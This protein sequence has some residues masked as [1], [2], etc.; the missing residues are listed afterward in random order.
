MQ[1]IRDGN[2]FDI[3]SDRVRIV[4]VGI[5][6]IVGQG[7]TN[8]TLGTKFMKFDVP[9]P[10]VGEFGRQN[11]YLQLGLTA[12][13]TA[14]L[15]SYA[16]AATTAL[17]YE[18]I[19][20]EYL[21]KPVGFGTVVGITSGYWVQSGSSNYNY[22][23]IP[24]VGTASTQYVVQLEDSNQLSA[25]S[26]GDVVKLPQHEMSPNLAGGVSIGMT[27]QNNNYISAKNG[28]TVE[29]TI[30]LDKIVLTGFGVTALAHGSGAVVGDYISIRRVFTIA[31]GRVGVT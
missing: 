6:T 28:L 25:I 5:G 26:A 4:E 17:G 19:G 3:H 18:I 2:P 30:G 20:T 13:Q 31:K 8:E 27:D 23:N 21:E 15:S 10:N 14:T 29:R 22:V 24:D 11:G 12:A 1:Y 7:T 16:G 9:T